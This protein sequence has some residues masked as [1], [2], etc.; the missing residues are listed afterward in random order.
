MA[1]RED[2]LQ[3]INEI[4]EFLIEEVIDFIEFLKTKKVKEK[5]ETTLLSEYSLAKDWLKPE[6]DKAWRN[7]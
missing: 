5:F 3:K 7:L 4:P 2:V 6:E 1:K